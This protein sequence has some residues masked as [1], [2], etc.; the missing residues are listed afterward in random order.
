[1]G[2]RKNPPPPEQHQRSE[3]PLLDDVVGELDTFDTAPMDSTDLLD[4][5]GWD[6]ASEPSDVPDLTRAVENNNTRIEQLTAIIERLIDERPL[7][8]DSAATSRQLMDGEIESGDGGEADGDPRDEQIL[9]LTEQVERLQADQELVEQQNQ[10]LIN[11]CAELTRTNEELSASVT[12]SQV[13]DDL[14]ELQ[15]ETLSWEERKSLI[16]QQMED[17]TFDAESFVESIASKQSA[18]SE[19]AD[20]VADPIAFVES[21]L[22]RLDRAQQDHQ[23][24]REEIE[25]L[26]HSLEERAPIIAGGQGD[27]MAVGAAALVGMLDDNEWVQ[28]ERDRLK[29]LQ[30]EWET[31][32]RQMEVESSLER[33]KL[34]RERQ[35]LANKLEEVENELEQA[36]RTSRTEEE[37]GGASRKW[38]AKLGIDPGN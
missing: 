35:E 27:Q 14:N 12:S 33:A 29:E 1:M 16:F 4:A 10:R 6:E 17:Q 37:T 15:S 25:M 26:Q 8:A 28:Q 22:E 2:R 20:E 23:R 7:A 9:E 32:F 3:I 5:P 13:R 11:E 30:T 19:S 18:G 31:K 38:L 36:R 24:Q 34:S 21:L